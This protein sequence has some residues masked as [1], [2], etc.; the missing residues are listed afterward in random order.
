MIEAAGGEA[1]LGAAGEKSRRVTWEEIHAAD[2]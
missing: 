2:P 1:L